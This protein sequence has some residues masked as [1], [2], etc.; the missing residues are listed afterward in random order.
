MT[1]QNFHSN[2][3]L[4]VLVKAKHLLLCYFFAVIHSLDYLTQGQALATNY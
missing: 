3:N 2:D 1:N 4:W